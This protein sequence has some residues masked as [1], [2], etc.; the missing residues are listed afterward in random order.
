MEYVK[1]YSIRTNFGRFISEHLNDERE[2]WIANFIG[3]FDS[4]YK[5]AE[6]K[7]WQCH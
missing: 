4:D 5:W 7:Y 1:G 2:E 6:F 3:E